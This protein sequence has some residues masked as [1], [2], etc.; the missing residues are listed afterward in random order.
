M[1]IM[2]SLS[3]SGWLEDV[4]EYCI[5]MRITGPVGKESNNS[6]I[7]WR[8]ITINDIPNVRRDF[9]VEWH[10]VSPC[11]ANWLDFLFGY[12]ASSFS[13]ASTHPPPYYVCVMNL[14]LVIDSSGGEYR[15]KEN[16]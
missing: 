8:N 12:S 10:S 6:A 7:V 2:T 5:K 3:A 16:V 15:S 13:F 14:E 9:R 1:P 11:L 4:V